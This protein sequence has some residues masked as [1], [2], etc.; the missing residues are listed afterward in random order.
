MKPDMDSNNPRLNLSINVP[1]GNDIIIVKTDVIIAMILTS[2][3]DLVYAYK[4]Y[5][6]ETLATIEADEIKLLFTINP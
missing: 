1:T 6:I 3:A 2:I 5:I 4:K